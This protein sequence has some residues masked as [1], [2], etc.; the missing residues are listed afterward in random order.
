M[1]SDHLM[2]FL[3]N[4]IKIRSLNRS[5]FFYCCRLLKKTNLIICRCSSSCAFIKMKQR[6]LNR[7][8][9][10]ARH[11]CPKSNKYFRMLKAESFYFCINELPNMILWTL[12]YYF[13]KKS[14]NNDKLQFKL[15]KVSS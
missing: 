5:L 4:L 15:Y 10:S 14:P 6:V 3:S 8:E 9:G 13:T 1:T 7:Y 11:S 2:Y 12:N